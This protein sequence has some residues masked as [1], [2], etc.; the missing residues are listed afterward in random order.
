MLNHPA[1]HLPTNPSGEETKDLHDTLAGNLD[2]PEM[3]LLFFHKANCLIES[4]ALRCEEINQPSLSYALLELFKRE[5]Y[6]FASALPLRSPL[7][8]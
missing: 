4:L 3:H 6:A 1:H 7:P 8:N 2:D 5:E